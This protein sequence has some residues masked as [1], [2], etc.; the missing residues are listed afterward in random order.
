[1]SGYPGDKGGQQQWA[2][3]APVVHVFPEQLSYNAYTKGG[4]SGAGVYGLWQGVPE[5]HTCADPTRGP[6]GIPNSGSRLSSAKWPFLIK[7]LNGDF[8]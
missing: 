4:D 3:T 7:W 1:M 5:Y 8:S 2:A 6:N